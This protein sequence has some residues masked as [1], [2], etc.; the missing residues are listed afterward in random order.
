MPEVQTDNTPSF[1][2]VWTVLEKVAEQQKDSA[3][4]F[5][6]RIVHLEN[7]FGE[8]A[9]QQRKSEADFNRRI[10]HLDN[11]FGEVSEY[12][13]APKLCEKFYEFG[14][15]FLRAN[16]NV[17]VNDRERDISLE[18]DIILENGDKAMLI[19]V[20][21]K[22]TRDRIV[23]HI[24]RLE[25]MRKHS[26]T[27]GDS[28]TFLGAVAGVIV[29]DEARSFALDQGLYLIEPSGDNFNITPPLGK[30]REW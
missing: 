11:L 26:N 5:N 28:R 12:M 17:K 23:A 3:E 20:K 18:I 9:E 22:L 13:I 2:R 14:F 29:T 16:R 21:N 15:N 19:E 1:E 8:V 7:L 24:E 4:D 10:G 6:R 30:P 27:H 25:K